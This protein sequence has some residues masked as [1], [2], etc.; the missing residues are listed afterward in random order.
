MLVRLTQWRAYTEQLRQRPKWALA[1]LG[2]ALLIWFLAIA[3]P[4]L[5]INGILLGSTLALAAVGLSLIYGIL[6]FA[7]IAHGE[8]PRGENLANESG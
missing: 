8:S 7:H 6:G 4:G 5:V 1:T 2:M 3:E